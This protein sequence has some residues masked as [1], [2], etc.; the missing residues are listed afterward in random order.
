MA[1]EQSELDKKFEQKE[2]ETKTGIQSQKNGK[3]LA[4]DSKNA[5]A[6]VRV[7]EDRIEIVVNEKVGIVITPDGIYTQ[8]QFQLNGTPLDNKKLGMFVDNPADMLFIPPTMVTPIMRY[9]PGNP[10]KPIIKMKRRLG[11]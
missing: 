1:I 11:V 10:L 7:K 5:N 8:G 6:F 3:L 9:L 2:N 4:S